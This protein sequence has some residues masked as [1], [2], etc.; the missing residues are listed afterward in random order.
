MIGW[1]VVAGYF[2]P[3]M[4]IALAAA[5]SLRRV[6]AVFRH[7]RPAEEPAEAP[8]GVWP[9]WFVAVTFWYTRRFGIFFL[10]GLVLDVAYSNF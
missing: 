4:L 10:V 2:T 7:P 3:F 8:R 6:F 1:L 5:P 9:L